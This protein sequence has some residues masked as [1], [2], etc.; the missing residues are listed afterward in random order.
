MEDGFG[1]SESFGLHLLQSGVLHY[2]TRCLVDPEF[3]HWPTTP[4]RV[5]QTDRNTPSPVAIYRL[6]ILRTVAIWKSV[7]VEPSVGDLDSL[8]YGDIARHWLGYQ[9]RQLARLFQRELAPKA[10]QLSCLF[11]LPATQECLEPMNDAMVIDHKP[12]INRVLWKRGHM[13]EDSRISYFGF[14]KDQ[15]NG[16]DLECPA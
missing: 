8:W 10:L 9:L 7:P 14:A 13:I 4:I 12:E 6:W 15:R 1:E 2:L 11:L 3:A 16:P 5:D